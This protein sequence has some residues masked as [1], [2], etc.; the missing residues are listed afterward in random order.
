MARSEGDFSTPRNSA[1][2]QIG[3]V[4]KKLEAK[5]R[6][7]RDFFQVLSTDSG[8]KMM[9][10][11]ARSGKCVICRG[12]ALQKCVE[13]QKMARMWVECRVKKPEFKSRKWLSIKW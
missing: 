3:T 2:Q 1:I 4:W 9:R 5:K 6:E 10:E 12:R 13:N 8:S 7:N 11:E